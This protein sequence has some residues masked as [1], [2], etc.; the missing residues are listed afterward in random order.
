MLGSSRGH[1]D[2]VRFLL[3]L[4]LVDR[5]AKNIDGKTAGDLAKTEEIRLSFT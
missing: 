2:V 5:D 3:S 4:Q 1:L